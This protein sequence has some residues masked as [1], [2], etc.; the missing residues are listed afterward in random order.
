LAPALR[1]SDCTKASDAVTVKFAVPLVVSDTEGGLKAKPETPVGEVTVAGP[2]KP[3]VKVTG[4]PKLAG[5]P[6][7]TLTVAGLPG[8][9]TGAVKFT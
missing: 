8:V 2:V 7:A 1:R 5:C 3:V 9:A 6:G 4:I